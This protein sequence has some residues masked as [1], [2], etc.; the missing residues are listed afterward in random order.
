[1]TLANKTAL[2]TGASRGIGRAVALSLAQAGADVAVNFKGS[3]DKAG[4]VVGEIRALGRRAIAV[5]ADVSRSDQVRDMVERV[6]RELGPV[7]VLVNN[8][9]MARQQTWDEVTEADW[10][11]VITV[12]LKSVFL[13][14]QAVLPDMR[15]ARWGR[16][17]NISSV[18]AQTGGLVGPH[19]AAS[20]GGINSL[21]HFLASRLA[22]EGITVNAV[23]PALIDTDMVR[24][25]VAAKPELL[26]V[27]RFGTAEEVAAMVL[28]VV[29]NGFVTNQTVN[30]NG[31]MYPV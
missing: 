12:N 1:M 24:Q 21:T 25:G 8:A 10:D 28:A 20:K 9:G 7:L 31:G 27:G 3:A 30:V 29:E 11:E 4:E 22:R 16:I 26:P 19:Y 14:C 5:Q 2:V 17:V 6:R 23:A 13:V 18:A 15:A